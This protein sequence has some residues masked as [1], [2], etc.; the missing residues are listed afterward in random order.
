MKGWRERGEWYKE[1][2]E[3]DEIRSQ[4]SAERQWVVLSHPSFQDCTK[5]DGGIYTNGCT[6]IIYNQ[7]HCHQMK[8]QFEIVRE[9]EQRCKR[10]GFVQIQMKATAHNWISQASSSG[11]CSH[12]GWSNTM[13]YLSLHL[14]YSFKTRPAD[15]VSHKHQCETRT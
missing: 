6:D 4:R 11:H 9:E 10:K 7:Y 5:T 1:G 14:T 13:A 2:E 12:R 8:I 15:P 3:G